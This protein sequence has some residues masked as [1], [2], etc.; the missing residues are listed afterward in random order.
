MSIGT[1]LTNAL[2]FPVKILP[3]YISL[4]ISCPQALSKHRPAE[5]RLQKCEIARMMRMRKDSNERSLHLFL[6]TDFR[7]IS[8]TL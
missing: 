1:N 3:A 5:S 7:N 8:Q 2:H 6:T 4:P